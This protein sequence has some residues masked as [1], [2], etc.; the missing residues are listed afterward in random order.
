MLLKY[1]LLFVTCFGHTGPSLGNTFF[2]GT[3][4]IVLAYVNITC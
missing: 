1:I 4:C 3:H 2:D